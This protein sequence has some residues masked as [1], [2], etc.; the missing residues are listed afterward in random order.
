MFKFLNIQMLCQDKYEVFYDSNLLDNKINQNTLSI[1]Y[2]GIDW[3]DKQECFQSSI[4]QQ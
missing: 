4:S 3:L 1:L 2:M